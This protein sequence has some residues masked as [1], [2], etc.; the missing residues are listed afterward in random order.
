MGDS[1]GDRLDNF[2][3]LIRK[4]IGSNTYQTGKRA[5]ASGCQGRRGAAHAPSCFLSISIITCIFRYK[6]FIFG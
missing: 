2:P 4:G 5:G 3:I 1:H 6:F